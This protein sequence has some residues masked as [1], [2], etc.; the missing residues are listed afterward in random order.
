MLP[1][2]KPSTELLMS[3]VDVR[4]TASLPPPLLLLL[5]QWRIQCLNFI[6]GATLTCWERNSISAESAAH[7][8]AAGQI[9][10]DIIREH[11]ITQS[12]LK[13]LINHSCRAAFCS[14]TIQSPVR[15]HLSSPRLIDCQGTTCSPEVIFAV[16]LIKLHVDICTMVRPC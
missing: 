13:H 11:W 12:G 16:S 3:D 5:P 15:L 6:C 14:P 7:V 10:E 4:S 8:E 1:R 9:M 2:V